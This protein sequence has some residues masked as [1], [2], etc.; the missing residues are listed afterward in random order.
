MKKLALQGGLYFGPAEGSQDFV[1]I[2]AQVK[3]LATTKHQYK[4]I[5]LDS[6]T[7]PFRIEMFAAEDR[8]V[9]SE[10]KKSQKEAEKGARKCLL[11][12]WLSCA[13]TLIF[14]CSWFVTLKTNGQKTIRA[15]S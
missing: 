7:K 10:F 12:A 13:Q 5:V 14:L 11:L 6:L 2:T 9:S 3:E 4:S 8:G 15:H 1:E